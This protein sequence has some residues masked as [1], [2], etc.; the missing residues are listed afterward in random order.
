MLLLIGFGDPLPAAPGEADWSAERLDLKV[1][2]DLSP[3]PRLTVGGTLQLELEAEQSDRLVLEL[4]TGRGGMRWVRLGGPTGASSTLNLTGRGSAA[5]GRARLDLAQPARRGDRLEVEFALELDGPTGQLFVGERFAMASWIEGWYPRLVASLPVA[6]WSNAALPGRTAFELPYGWTVLSDGERLRRDVGAGRGREYWSSERPVPRSFVAAPFT[7]IV[8][9]PA[10]EQPRVYLLDG[11]VAQADALTRRIARLR[12]ALEAKLGRLPVP[13]S[14]FAEIPP[15]LQP[16]IAASQPGFIVVT[17]RGLDDPAGGDLLLAHELSH[18]WWGQ[19]V[20]FIGP[21]RK[22]LGEALAQYSGLLALEVDGGPAAL[23]RRL[24]GSPSGADGTTTK[25]GGA[26]SAYRRL[27]QAERDH[28]LATLSTSRLGP[29]STHDLALTKGAWV[30]DMLRRRVGDER[31]FGTLQ[32]LIERHRG[33]ALGLGAFRQAF[34]EAGGT[35]LMRFFE[36]WLDRGGLPRLEAT[37][38]TLPQVG[39]DSP[40]QEVVVHQVQPGPAYDLD[41]ELQV[42]FADGTARRLTV[43]SDGRQVTETIDAGST[44]LDVQVDPDQRLLLHGAG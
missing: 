9:D 34:V 43:R 1:R 14:G 35:R 10:G 23:R 25:P 19:S 32:A 33:K 26:A 40:D 18:A 38:S 15:G 8:D 4:N 21:G 31:F 36:Q 5:S 13:R 24:A 11:T 44:I 12:R 42:R 3:R 2:I 20:G 37:W 39:S 30:L 29:G 22:F 27:L 17:A 7:G 6:G 41:I 16:W 28:P